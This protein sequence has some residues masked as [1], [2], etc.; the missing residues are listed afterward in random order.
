V[1]EVQEDEKRINAEGMG[2]IKENMLQVASQCQDKKLLKIY[3]EVIALMAR[4]YLHKV[5]PQLVPVSSF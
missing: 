2:L 1:H 4:E 3:S 5:W